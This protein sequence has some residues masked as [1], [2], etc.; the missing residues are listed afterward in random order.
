[1]RQ[2]LHRFRLAGSAATALA[3]SIG[4]LVAC[5]GGGVVGSG[6]TGKAAGVT[7]GTVNGFGS[8]IVD[9]VRFDDRSAPTYNEVGPGNDVL[10]TVRLG[11][12]VSVEYEV[13]GVAN[14][15]RLDAAL[16]GPVSALTGGAQFTLLGQTV[17]TNAGSAS[18]PITQ[19]GGGYTRTADVHAGDS[20]E[21]HGLLV[22]QSGGYVIQAT[23][24]EK[25][26][27]T[28]AYLR[29]TGL[30]SNV[31][32]SSTLKLGSLTVDTSAATVLPGGTALA[33]GQ[34][35]T[36]LAAPGTLMAGAGGTP[37]LKAVQVRARLLAVSTLDDFVSGALSRL[38]TSAR[39]FTIGSLQ[40]RYGAATLLPAG[41]ALVE[42]KYVLVS[43]RV[44]ADG[45]LTATTVTVRN[46]ESDDEGEL[47][48]NVSG[49]VAASRQFS[50]RDVVVDASVAAIS[51]C[52]ATGLADGLFVE[53]HGA[54]VSTGVRA[55]SVQC[56]AESAT[57]TIER[58]GTVGAVDT[59][60]R[61]FALVTTGGTALSVKWTD[62]T[63]FDGGMP[64][65]LSGK[66]VEV[67]GQLSGTLLT[68]GKVEI[69]D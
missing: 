41:T 14:V 65:T 11:H 56:E 30:A 6:G 27:A 69:E 15:V 22:Q 49:Y 35:L 24:I 57:A 44:G 4:A 45:A 54:L 2:L 68:A 9:G 52:P 50:V 23:R 42:G 66:R 48:G 1:M 28:P 37:G 12:R 25:L 63:F 31:V 29:V 62:T 33:N 61:T 10:A 21:V 19:F 7:V 13:A 47:K 38:D 3:L 26:A 67:Q 32:G 64:A 20:A 39:T 34:T 59:A 8:V 5:G 46:A 58:K 17:T 43:G 16:A 60:A 51:G 40:V 53:V 18:G 55:K 36:V